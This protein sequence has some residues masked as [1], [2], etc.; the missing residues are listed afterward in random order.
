MYNPY[1]KLPDE[2]LDEH[3]FLLYLHDIAV[4]LLKLV[5]EHKLTTTNLNFK[6]SSPTDNEDLIKWLEDNDYILELN[7]IQ[8]PHILFSLLS[9]FTMYMGDSLHSIENGRVSV[10]Y[11]ISRKPI[12][13]TLFYICWLYADSDELLNKI[14]YSENA[15]EYDISEFKRNNKRFIVDV[16]NTSTSAVNPYLDGTVLYDLIYEKNEDSLVAIWNKALHIVTNDRKYPTAVGNLNFIFADNDIWT[17]FW[18]YY[19]KIIPHLYHFALSVTLLTFEDTLHIDGT[20]AKLNKMFL[21]HKYYKLYNI[22][23]DESEKLV[24]GIL[25]HINITCDECEY[26]YLTDDLKT[27]FNNYYSFEC[28]KCGEFERVGHYYINDEQIEESKKRRTLNL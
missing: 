16:L 19:Y 26:N 11:A 15:R 13:D 12:Q 22:E 23:V 14:Q 5:D 1:P 9:D 3:E 17:D 7:Y 24:N 2:F 8:K 18:E 25:E 28:P 21:N 10:A 4:S 27:I 20:I 6:S